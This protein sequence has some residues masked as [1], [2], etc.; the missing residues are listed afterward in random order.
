MNAGDLRRYRA[1]YDVI[2]TVVVVDIDFE[3]N[4]TSM[5]K[6]PLIAKKLLK[7]GWFYNHFR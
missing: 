2:S 6:P 5:N 3:M 7:S 4:N 1:H